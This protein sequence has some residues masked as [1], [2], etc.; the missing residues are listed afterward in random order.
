MAAA[1]IQP[2]REPRPPRAL[3]EHAID[4]LHF[5]R[6]TME[7]AGSFTAL[8]GWGIAGTGVLALVAAWIA[9]GHA[10]E[11]GLR[12][13]WLLTWLGTALVAATLT[14]TATVRKAGRVGAAVFAGPGLRLLMGFAAPATAA[15]VLTPA[16]YLAGMAP[17]LPGMW[18]LLYGAALITGG[19]FS[20]RAVPVMGAC[21]ML[22]GTLAVV[23]TS[24]VGGPDGVTYVRLLPA[25]AWMA[26]G[27]G[28]LHIGFGSYI[29]RR[30]GG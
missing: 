22:L 6:R 30:H 5:I 15:A 17:L 2:T 14:T 7:R 10:A 4:N 12:L 24:I 9:A 29:A 25:D 16:L 26:S 3:H 19:I 28:V 8:S 21:F 20:I 1:P 27:F 23:T 18:L 11:G 13:N